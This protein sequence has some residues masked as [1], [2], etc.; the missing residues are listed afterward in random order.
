M[1]AAGGPACPPDGSSA[2]AIGPA[3]P[4]DVPAIVAMAHEFAEDEK[5]RRDRAAGRVR[6]ALGLP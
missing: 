4:Q 5:A 1:P 6:V 2:P 3:R